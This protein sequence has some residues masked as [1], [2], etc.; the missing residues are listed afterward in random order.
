MIFNL[1]ILLKISIYKIELWRIPIFIVGV[2][3]VID[4]LY[5][6][7]LLNAAKSRNHS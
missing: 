6:V 3:I 1:N 2:P 5:F 4:G 7:F